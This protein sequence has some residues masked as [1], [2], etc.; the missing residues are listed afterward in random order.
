MSHV[1]RSIFLADDD[2]DDCEIFRE[3]LEEVNPN[4]ELVICNDGKELMARLETSDLPMMILLDI[5]MPRK[6]GIECL[7]EIKRNDKL[8]VVPVVMISTSGDPQV[9][10]STRKLHADHYIQKPENF[11]KLK[12]LIGKLLSRGDGDFN[13]ENFILIP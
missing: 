3:A 6:G 1:S 11:R 2:V 9:I 5:N 4:V 13:S 8:R 7:K 12:I 10:A